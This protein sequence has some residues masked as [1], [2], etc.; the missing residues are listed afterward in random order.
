MFGC[1]YVFPPR[2]CAVYK[3]FFFLFYFHKY[4]MDFLWWTNTISYWIG[5]Y[6]CLANCRLFVYNVCSIY[7]PFDIKVFK[8][9]FSSVN[10]EWRVESNKKR[11]HGENALFHNIVVKNYVDSKLFVWHTRSVR[12]SSFYEPKP[13][14]TFDWISGQLSNRTMP[15]SKPRFEFVLFG[16]NYTPYHT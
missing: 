11:Q 5:H 12:I 10:F 7:V 13:K 3:I 15:R 9:C 4:L 2:L 8:C 16:D 14:F 6:Y 1:L